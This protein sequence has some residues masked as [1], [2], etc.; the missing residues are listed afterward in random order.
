M[1]THH[2]T[3]SIEPA[4]N[5]GVS[6]ARWRYVGIAAILAIACFLPFAVSGYRLSQFSQV[7]IYAIALLGLNILTGFN[8]QISLGQSAF[9]AIG[10]YTTALL[11]D[12]TAIPYWAT[13]PLAGAGGGGD[14]RRHRAVQVAD[15]WPGAL[16]ALLSAYVS[17]DSFPVF[18][19]IKFLVGSVV[20]GIASISGVFIGALFIEFMP[21]I[22]DQ[23]S[24]AAPDAIFGMLLI[25]SMYLMP[26]GAVG[27][28][29]FIR[30]QLRR[31]VVA[32]SRRDA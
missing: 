8:G 26:K 4:P 10:A 22:S 27:V 12:K 28:F 25:A 20:G 3:P 9:Y 1:A 30:V 13:V 31:A 18:L 2:Q 7:L 17:P 14:G 16:G 32:S 5:A 19:S 15:L 23:M 24:K 6:P 11:L 29:D 21:N